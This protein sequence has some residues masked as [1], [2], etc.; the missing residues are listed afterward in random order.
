MAAIPVI[1][2]ASLLMRALSKPI[3][4]MIKIEAKE[5]SSFRI[6][7]EKIGQGTHQL[8]ARINVMSSGYKFLRVAPLP[9]EEALELGAETFSESLI[10]G[11]AV[12]V[13]VWEYG[14]SKEKDLKREEEGEEKLEEIR[15]DM[16]L[17]RKDIANLKEILSEFKEEQEKSKSSLFSWSVAKTDDNKKKDKS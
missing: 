1:K 13:M 4:R 14:R 8:R 5:I 11:I 12:G 17:L 3:A 10:L 15:R 7:F 2:L 6:F 16:V 9:M